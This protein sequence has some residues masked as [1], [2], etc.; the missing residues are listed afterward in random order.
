M[1][2][3]VITPDDPWFVHQGSVDTEPRVAITLQAAENK[4]GGAPTGPY[5]TV[6]IFNGDL[7]GL[8]N[9]QG[10]SLTGEPDD[11]NLD[12]ASGDGAHPGWVNFCPDV[13]KGVRGL[14]AEGHEMVR[15]RTA[16]AGGTPM[17]T[18]TA[19]TRIRELWVPNGRGGWRRAAV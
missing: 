1:P 2:H 6:Y 11:L 14:D 17:I 9:I 8:R 7:G 4:S 10:G 18:H 3:V 16:A 12:V 19:P 13:G 15:W 5:M